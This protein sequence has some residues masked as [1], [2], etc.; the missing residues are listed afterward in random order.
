MWENH[1]P[2]CDLPPCH[3]S[4][5][6]KEVAYILGNSTGEGT[7]NSHGETDGSAGDGTNANTE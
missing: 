4:S 2:S 3:V 1:E 7:V 5:P 6:E